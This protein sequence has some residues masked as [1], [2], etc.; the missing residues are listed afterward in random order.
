MKNVVTTDDAMFYMG[1][2]DGRRRVRYVRP[3]ETDL[4][5]HNKV[6]KT[7]CICTLVYGSFGPGL[8]TAVKHL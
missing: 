5:K 6:C 2:R 1:G 7:S 4:N 3:T 8:A